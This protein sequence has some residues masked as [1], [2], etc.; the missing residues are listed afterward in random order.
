MNKTNQ[1]KL[2]TNNKNK[3]KYYCAF[4]YLFVRP[5][6]KSQILTYFDYDVERAFRVDYNDLKQIKEFYDISISKDFLAKRDKIDVDEAYKNSLNDKVKIVTVE[7]EKYPPLLKQ[8]PDFP[9]ALFYKGDIEQINYSNT[10]AIV[11]SRNASNEAKIS[12]NKIISDL[13][14]TNITIV[15]GLAYGIDAMA[16]KAAIDNNLKTIG[17]IGS[18][19]DIVYPSQNKQLYSQ[20]E[21]EA[22]VI[23]SEYPLKTSPQP[24]NF[25]Q[26][27]RIVTGI[28]KGTLVAEAKMKSGAM[29]S[30]N[31]TLDYNRELM[32]MPGNILNPNTEGIYHIIKQGAGIVTKGEDILNHLGLEIV[33]E[34]KKNIELNE[35]QKHVL[36]IIAI[37]AQGFDEI[38]IKSKFETSKL[39]VVLTE[40]ELKG[41]IIQ[42]DNKYYKCR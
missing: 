23:F 33:E 1:L 26:R 32:A 19:L 12:L 36:D 24:M 28:C 11:G 20:I 40:L 37:E 35:T 18:G 16:H 42:K 13:K 14:N 4:S 31:L 22:G 21:N 10:L 25:P 15:S 29:I 7:D 17:V 8:I 27:N 9:L 5:L 34:N 38:M 41:L 39:M 6:L 2:G 3:L 30:A